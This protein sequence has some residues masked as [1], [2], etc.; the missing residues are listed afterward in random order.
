MT[1]RI[2]RDHVRE[3]VVRAR[4][5]ILTRGWCQR[6]PARSRSDRAVIDVMSP[7]AAS[8]SMN[9]AVDRAAR[10]LDCSSIGPEAFA[11]LVACWRVL[12]SEGLLKAAPDARG[13][14]RVPSNIFAVIADW[15]DSLDGDAH[16][17]SRAKVVM[18]LTRALSIVAPRERATR[19]SDGGAAA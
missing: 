5:L 9:G 10:T 18:V 8:F 15:N 17:A 7:D 4:D 19:S 6:A 1:T 11:A 14:V 12:V 3:I 16:E 2:D 13:E